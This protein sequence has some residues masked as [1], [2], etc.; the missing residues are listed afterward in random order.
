MKTS[1]INASVTEPVGLAIGRMKRLLFQPFDL[2]RWF[3]I[4]FTAWLASLAEPGF[5]G[6]FNFRQP[7]G[8]R[9]RN[10]GFDQVRDFV[11]ENLVWLLPLAVVLVVLGIGLWILFTWL[12]SRG[13]FMFLHC[14]ATEKAEV[15]A[16][17]REFARE[18]NSLFVFRLVL[19]L[20]GGVVLLPTM[21]LTGF[22]L[23][24]VF[25]N[26]DGTM[27]P[28]GVIALV[29]LVLTMVGVGVSLAAIV[30]LTTDFVVPIMFLRRCRCRAAWG[31][32]LTLLSANIGDFVVY[33]LFRLALGI[34]LAV[35]VFL[36]VIATCCIA[37]C[38][39]ALPYLGTVFLLPLL[40]FTRCYSL[41]YLAQ[42]GREYEVFAVPAAGA[43]AV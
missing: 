43:P 27:Q 29:A 4:G 5:G 32:F 20:T 30:M 8:G 3:A 7:G 22:I 42:Y 31:E 38:L 13:H 1:S 15:A 16:P 25:G 19:G 39:M 34:G 40:M 14:V 10:A 33:L 9:R 12:S 24:Q 23:H 2:E 36:V 6:G 21:G 26:G 28:G 41:C 17:W 35:L 18:G 37:G 11:M